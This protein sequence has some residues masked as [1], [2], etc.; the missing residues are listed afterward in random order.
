MPYLQRYGPQRAVEWS[1]LN[2]EATYPCLLSLIQH[3]KYVFLVNTIFVI[4]LQV[5][6]S[7]P[8]FYST[9]LFS[10]AIFKKKVYSINSVVLGPG[11]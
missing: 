10:S 9:Y 2:R 4:S 11:K 1:L 5:S 8:H 6:A 3:N 7:G